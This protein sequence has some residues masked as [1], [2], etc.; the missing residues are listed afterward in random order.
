MASMLTTRDGVRSKT[1]R[2]EHQPLRLVRG[3]RSHERGERQLEALVDRLGTR[4][5]P[6]DGQPS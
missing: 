6:E 3:V 5:I 1:N 2:T 4:G